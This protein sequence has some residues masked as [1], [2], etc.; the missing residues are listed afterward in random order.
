MIQ[1]TNLRTQMARSSVVSTTLDFPWSC[2]LYIT[3]QSG[4]MILSSMDI[5]IF[6]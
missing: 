6:V 4:F 3:E 1:K 5:Y 2:A